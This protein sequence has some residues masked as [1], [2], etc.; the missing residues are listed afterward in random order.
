MALEGNLPAM[1]FVVQR[2]CGRAPEAPDAAQPLE[3]SLPK[4]QTAADCS[5]AIDRVVDAVCQG[6][7]D[8][9]LPRCSRT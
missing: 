4:L 9:S 8:K 2:T 5:V 3:I 1:K 7:L 6:A